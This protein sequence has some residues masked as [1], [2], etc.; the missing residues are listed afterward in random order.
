MILIQQLLADTNNR[1][2]FSNNKTNTTE[3]RS[4]HICN[5]STGA[6]TYR[7]FVDPKGSAFSVRT[8]L[9]YDIL[10]GANETD[11]IEYAEGGFTLTG[12]AA[13]A[14][15]CNTA[16]AISITINGNRL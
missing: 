6:V 16:N 2:L 8:A 9:F 11:L 14:A 12:S 13:I 4:I 7:I 1:K 10:L 3:I 15:R 5:N